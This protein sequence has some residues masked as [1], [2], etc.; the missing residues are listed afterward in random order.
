LTNKHQNKLGI[1]ICQ[2]ITRNPLRLDPLDWKL[3]ISRKPSNFFFFHIGANKSIILKI[4]GL[5]MLRSRKKILSKDPW[6]GSQYSSVESGCYEV[7]ILLVRGGRIFFTFQFYNGRKS[8]PLLT[9]NF[10]TLKF[11]Y[12]DGPNLCRVKKEMLVPHLLKIYFGLG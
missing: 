6:N 11:G 10:V 9:N 12:G 8:S 3:Y 2:D 5:Q 4:G 7:T 1:K